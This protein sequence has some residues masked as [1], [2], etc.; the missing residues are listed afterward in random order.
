MKKH[1]KII[2]TLFL[3]MSVSLSFSQGESW[4][5]NFG[6]GA[7]MHF[8]FGGPPVATVGSAMNTFEGCAS[9]GTASGALAFYT[10]GNKVWGANNIQMPN[11]FGLFGNPSSTQA[12][13]IVPRPGNPNLYYIFCTSSGGGTGNI[14]Y[15]EVDMTLNAPWGNVTAVKNIVIG[16]NVGEK[17]TAVGH[18]NGVDIWVICHDY[19]NSDYRAF[20]VTSAGVNA[21]PVISSA[22]APCSGN[23]V[24]AIK[25]SPN[26]RKIAY[27]ASN[28]PFALHVADFNNSTGVV[29]NAVNLA[30]SAGVIPMYGLEFSPNSQILYGSKWAGS[31][32]VY[33]WDLCGNAA[34]ILASEL[35]VGTGLNT[36]GSAQLGPDGK[37][38]I[39]RAGSNF[40]GVIN[41]PNTLGAGCNYV[42]NGFNISPGTNQYGLPSFITSFM[43]PPMAPITST[44][45]CLNV[46]FTSP[47]LNLTANCSANSNSISAHLWNFGDPASGP[48]NTST[49]ANPS[50]AYTAPGVYTVN[51]VLSLACGTTALSHTVS[52]I[53]CSPMVNVNSPTI[54][55]GS[56]AALT[57]TASGG[58]GPYTYTWSPNIGAGAG[59]HNICPNATTIYTVTIADS[60][61]ATASNTVAFIVNPTPTMVIASSSPTMCMN[62]F[63]GST[64]TLTINANGATTYSWI[65]ISGVTTN[66]TVGSNIIATALPPFVAGTGSVIG[67]IGSCTSMATFTVG[68]IPNPVIAVS[69][70]S[71]CFGTSAVLTASNAS[72]YAW[73]PFNT[74]SASTG[75]S[76]I[77]NPANTTVYSVI[78][79]SLNCNSITETGTV[80]VIANPTVNIISPSA[81]ICAGTSIGLTAFGANTYSWSPGSTLDNTFNDVVIATPLVTTNYTVVGTANSCTHTAVKQ[82]I[83]ITLPNLQA[84]C[85]KSVI[86]YGD[87]TT[88]NANGASSYNWSPS[89]GLSSSTSNFITANP[90]ASTVYTLIASNGLCFASIMVPVIVVPSPKLNIST[91]NQKICFGNNTTLFASGADN[92]NWTPAV[93]NSNP[94]TAIV[95]PSVTTNYTITGYNTAGTVVCSFAK[96][97]EI[98]VVPLVVPSISGSVTICAGE[99]VKLSAGGGNT[100]NWYPSTGISLVSDNEPY[101]KPLITTVY[102]VQVS[103]AG[104]CGVTATVLI[105]VNPLPTV[106]AGPDVTYNLDEPMFLNAKGSGTLKW[107]L[108]EGIICKDCPNTQIKPSNSSCYQI[109]AINE[110]GCKAIDEVCIDVSKDYNIYIPNVFTP[111]ADGINDVFL[112]Y[113]TGL[114]KLEVIVFDRWGEKLFTSNEQLKG[115]DGKYK[116]V[117]L[118]ED[119]YPYQVIFNTLDGK[120]HTKTGHVTLL[121]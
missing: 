13:I 39:T 106:D 62:S 101:V 66:S 25:V 40:L 108:G 75:S 15:S 56:C 87:Q 8:P 35:M 45:N 2:T 14:S 68:V 107:I 51:L 94:N 118:K 20:L 27:C 29:S 55:S 7:S 1:I 31:N 21:T 6:N 85:E 60:F 52:V 12:A 98:E 78:G 11:G 57:A 77:A 109:Q 86:C 112:V 19:T 89:T 26:G 5:W 111:N 80:N 116:G 59:P 74:L 110:F 30:G 48:A 67:T 18:C 105:K 72:T 115:W 37:I 120:K 83:V 69:S 119:V 76:V 103:N 95:S 22:G 92:Y 24:G 97:I 90:A 100:Y 84:I 36:H 43:A 49:L 63:N 70:A 61:N 46:N 28:G 10:D 96:E 91:S 121:K 73:S 53:S 102:S 38:Y 44:V 64:N 9:I 50:H 58:T 4:R 65:G 47:T 33:Q 41:N 81:T 104:N 17:L 54:C 79:S 16:T 93:N 113:G 42:A 23:V 32:Q 88:I 34:Q 3:I 117:D 82:V 71:M 114:T 99:S